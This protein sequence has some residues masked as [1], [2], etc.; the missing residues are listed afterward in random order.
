MGNGVS[1]ENQPV[2]T[3]AN[4]NQDQYKHAQERFCPSIAAF[5]LGLV[6]APTFMGRSWL[7]LV[8]RGESLKPQ[9][10]TIYIYNGQGSEIMETWNDYL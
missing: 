8:L 1:T 3:L 10:S 9:N 5:A 2:E 6:E 7:Q 4:I